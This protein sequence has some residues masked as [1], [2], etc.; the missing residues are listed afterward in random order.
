MSFPYPLVRRHHLSEGLAAQFDALLAEIW[1]CFSAD[2]E[3]KKKYIYIY[4]LTEKASKHLLLEQKWLYE[5]LSVPHLGTINMN[6]TRSLPPLNII[7]SHQ[8]LILMDK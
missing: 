1:V 3:S 7:T 6:I 4:I 8:L 5:Y 2:E